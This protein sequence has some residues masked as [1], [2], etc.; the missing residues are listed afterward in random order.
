VEQTAPL[1]FREFLNCLKILRHRLVER[2]INF[3]E[4]LSL[5]GYIQIQANGLPIAWTALS[6]TPQN[7][8]HFPSLHMASHTPD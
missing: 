1:I 4:A 6:E 5:N 3:L 7:P 2:V 8:M